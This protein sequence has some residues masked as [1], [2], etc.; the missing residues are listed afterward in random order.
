MAVVGTLEYWSL[1]QPVIIYDNEETCPLSYW[2]LG[3]P[4]VAELGVG[5]DMSGVLLLLG[6]L[7]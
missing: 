2:S 6:S 7:F 5:L 1:G 4:F 3:V